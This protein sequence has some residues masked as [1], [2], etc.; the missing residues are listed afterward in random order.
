M[1]RYIVE[2]TEVERTQLLD[3][4]SKGKVSARKLNRAHILLLADEGRTDEAIAAA[5]HVSRSTVER[6]RRRFVMGNLDFALTEQMRPGARRKL[7]GKQEAFL[8][9]TVCSSPPEGRNRW[10]LQLLADRL[11]ELK[12]VDSISR[13][14]IRRTLKKTISSR[15]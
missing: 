8:V 3:L 7:D 2:L 9:A 4:T 14:T 5:L 12:M 6:A 1:K 10:T 15:G 11:I 13:D